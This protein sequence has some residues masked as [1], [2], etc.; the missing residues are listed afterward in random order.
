MSAIVTGSVGTISTSLSMILADRLGRKVLF[1]V[2]GIQMLV[3][4]VMIGSIMADQLGDHGGFSIGYAYLI[5]VL[6]CVYKAGFAFSWGPLRWLV[7]SEN[8]PLEIISAGQIITVAGESKIQGAIP[9]KYFQRKSKATVMPTGTIVELL[10]KRRKYRI[11]PRMMKS[12]EYG[13]CYDFFEFG[14]WCWKILIFSGSSHFWKFFR[15]D[16]G[17]LVGL[18]LRWSDVDGTISEEILPRSEQKDE[19]RHQI[20]RAIGRKVSILIGGVAFLAGSAYG[21]SAFNIYMLIFGRLLLGVGIGFGNQKWHHQNTEE[22]STLAFNY[23]VLLELFL[24]IF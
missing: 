7:P 14:Y 22:H 19:R 12:S 13:N 9:L 5:L 20:T 3:S 21:G 23:V 1:L 15:K 18:F 17:E 4:R 2:G 10:V 24:L 6:I 11:K 8:F 16:V